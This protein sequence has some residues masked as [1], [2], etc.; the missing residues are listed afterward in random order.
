[1]HIAPTVLGV[2]KRSECVVSS[3][4]KEEAK[5]SKEGQNKY[6]LLTSTR[7]H[8]GQSF[9]N[10]Q[11]GRS[12]CMTACHEHS[13]INTRETINKNHAPTSLAL[14]GTPLLKRI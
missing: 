9:F 11:L 4:T 7:S 5:E 6:N 13:T 1:M 12:N 10:G 14:H 3:A 2:T 8:V